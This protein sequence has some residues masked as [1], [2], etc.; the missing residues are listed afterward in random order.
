MFE[1]FAVFN[2]LV[3][4]DYMIEHAKTPGEKRYY[5][6]QFLQIKGL[7]FLL[8]A[9]DASLEQAIYDGVADGSLT[10][11]DDLDTL[12][13]ESDKNFSMWPAEVPALK[14]RWERLV[15]AYE[16]PLY[17]V[18]YVYAGLL[19]LE[20]FQ[21]WKADPEKFNQA[22]AALLENG[23][24][25]PPAD[26]LEKYLDINLHNQETLVANASS[27]VDRILIELETNQ[28]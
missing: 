11:A 2:E 20:Y 3:L 7:E 8:G 17:Y 27:V 13:L 15:L 23:F 6:E 22:Y 5:L 12:T 16:D 24:D 14:A 25:A 21:L 9:K 4:A 26:L 1:S 18:N 10:N 19:G 28:Q